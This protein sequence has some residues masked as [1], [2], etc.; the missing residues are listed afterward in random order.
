MLIHPRNF[1]QETKFR[2]LGAGAALKIFIGA[3][4]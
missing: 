2:P 4:P 1:F 3:N